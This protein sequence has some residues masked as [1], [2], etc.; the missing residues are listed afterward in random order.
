LRDFAP[1]FEINTGILITTIS[2][3]YRQ[4]IR[5]NGEQVQS[6]DSPSFL[7]LDPAL[8]DEPVIPNLEA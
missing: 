1:V 4:G 2:I 6:V 7:S 5:N 8:V 3:P